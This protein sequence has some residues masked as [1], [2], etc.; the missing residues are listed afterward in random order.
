M[1]KNKKLFTRKEFE[2]LR[3]ESASKMA[4][5]KKLQEDALDLLT[6][7]DKHRWIHQTTWMG[8]PLLNLPRDMFAI[9]EIIFATK[10]KYI[11][12]IGVA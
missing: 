5:D 7:S 11:I 10:P 9:P 4:S 3:I 8:E 1:V 6:R 12:E 2:K